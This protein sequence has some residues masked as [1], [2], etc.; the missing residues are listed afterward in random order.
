MKRKILLIVILVIAGI[1]IYQLL[2]GRLFQVSPFAIG[3]KKQQYQRATIYYQ[4]A[5]ISRF[6]S[7]DS[8]VRVVEQFHQL[9]FK[10]KVEIFI[11]DSDRTYHRYTGSTARFITT[12]IYGRIFISARA[13]ND[14]LNQKIHLDTYLRHELSHSLLFQ[15]MSIFHSLKYPGWFMEGLATYSANQMGVDGYLTPREVITRIKEG[16]FVEPK[17]WGSIISSKGK[18]VNDCPLDNKYHFIYSEYALIVRD[19]VQI[20]GK[21]NFQKFLVRSTKEKDFY[22]LFQEFYRI[23]FDSYTKNFRTKIL[24]TIVLETFSQ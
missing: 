1:L 22:K 15:N 23:D 14:Y 24:R 8:L 17:D 19:L 16:Y 4:S 9:N 18:S 13:V 6:E 11:C 12:L 2:Y 5:D 10:R 7:I 21:E 3:F 20:E